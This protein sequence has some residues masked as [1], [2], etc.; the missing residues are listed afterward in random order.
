MKRVVFTGLALAAILAAG[1]AGYRLGLQSEMPGVGVRL[2]AAPI[3]ATA[4]PAVS[5]PIIY[6]R[7]P[8][9]APIYSATP[10]RM[11]D[12]RAFHA[13]RASE[14]VS[15]EDKPPPIS[16]NSEKTRPRR[17]LYYRNAMGLP[18]TSP[19]PKKDSMGMDYIPV[20]AGDDDGSPIIKVAPGR[21]QT[22]GV[23]SEPVERRAIVVPIRVPGT[24]T[25]DERRVA[26]V[27]TRS[28]AFIDK[29]ENVT[30]GDRV[31]KGEPLVHLYSPEIVAA[32]AQLVASPGFE[33]SRRR[34]ENLNVAPEVIAEIERTR[35]IPL[36][37]TWSSPRDGVVLERN[38]IDGMK[39]AAGQVL[40]R[41]A[42]V[43]VLWVL[44]DVPEYD[45]GN[46]KVGESATVRVRGL[47]G[48]TFAGR[49]A[50]IYPQVKTATR[51]TPVRIELPN[52]DG[53]FRP[54]MYADVEINTGPA[55]KVVA[56]PNSAIMDTGTRQ[57]VILDRGGGR[58]EPRK[59][60]V[61]MRGEGFTEIRSG[62][63]EGDRVVIAA[64]FLIDAESNLKAALQSM[65]T[66]E[67]K[68]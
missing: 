61:G 24:I 49:V 37:I 40:F 21:L 15:F 51:T 8:D 3:V 62:V 43:S 26:V 60:K 2:G 45:L 55:A 63:I 16:G 52:P 20:Y 23:R 64:N 13:V 7:D 65:A 36:T 47:P 6:Y 31:T 42:D 68:R 44:A 14:D 41:I 57:I 50:L 12:G 39:A 66:S 46:V 59:V 10:R 53:L 18:D 9:G 34:M 5:G 19:V 33:G 4:K 1:V 29:V 38:A 54:D 27:A 22:T 17:I 35:K 56:V 32:G 58:F 25:L 28:D 30:T 11:K 48:H 67:A